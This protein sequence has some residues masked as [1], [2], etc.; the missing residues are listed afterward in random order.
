MTLPELNAADLQVAETYWSNSES[1]RRDFGGD[2]DTFLAFTRSMIGGVSRSRAPGLNGSD[3]A[4]A[5]LFFGWLGQKVIQ[6]REWARAKGA[7]V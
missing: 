2:R 5:H 1:L 7:K 6:N 3:D 4:A